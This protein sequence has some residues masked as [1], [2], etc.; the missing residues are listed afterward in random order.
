MTCGGYGLTGI[1]LAAT[2]QLEPLP[3][4]TASVER[5]PVEGLAEGL[6]RLRELTPRSPCVYGTT[7]RSPGCLAMASSTSASFPKGPRRRARWC[8]A[9]GAS[10]PRAA[11]A[12]VRS[13]DGRVPARRWFQLRCDPVLP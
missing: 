2:L 10:P 11:R 3:G 5:V 8:H 4:W 13:G 9:T 1:I 6:A 12:Q 7:T